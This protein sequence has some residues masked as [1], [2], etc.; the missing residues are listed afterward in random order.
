MSSTYLV[1]APQALKPRPHYANS[2][3]S[4]Y[5]V[6]GTS[7]SVTMPN[8]SDIRDLNSTNSNPGPP[9]VDSG[10]TYLYMPGDLLTKTCSALSGTIQ[11]GLCYVDCNLLT[12]TGGFNVMIENN[13]NTTSFQ[14]PYNNLI[15]PPATSSSKICGMLM[16][17]TTDSIPAILGTPFLRSVYAVFDWD[18]QQVYFGKKANCGNNVVAIG[19]GSD[20]VPTTGGC[21]SGSSSEG[22][23]PASSHYAVLIMV[24][25]LTSLIII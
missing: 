3:I 11:S 19:N 12:A 18:N 7:Y 21:G 9:I 6:D 24:G 10:T 17:Q 16:A 4:S 8:S 13:G 5:Y 2:F 14:I 23:R 22:A 25:L 15:F 1:A 20:A